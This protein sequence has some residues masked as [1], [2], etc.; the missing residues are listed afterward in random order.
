MR[1]VEVPP[2]TDLMASLGAVGY[3]FRTAL[4][5]IVDNSIT[6]GARNVRISFEGGKSPYIA[7]TDDGRGMG[8][9]AL[10]VAMQL[11]G[12]GP[13]SRRAET[14]LGRFGL[15]LKTASFSQCRCLSVCT[16][17]PD[18][19]IG[20]QW[21]Q[22]RIARTQRWALATFVEEEVAEQLH[23]GLEVPSP[24]GTTVV[25]TDLEPIRMTWGEGEKGLDLAMDGAVDWLSLVF[26]RFLNGDHVERINI[27]VNGN[28]VVGKDP[29]L[30]GH[31]ATSVQSV[32]TF[33]TASGPVRVTPVTLPHQDKLGRA[34][35]ERLGLRGERL[36]DTQ[37]FYVYRANRLLRRGKWFHQQRATD[38]TK[39]TRV[40]VDVGND[41]DA[42]WSLDIKKSV[43]EPPR[44][45]LEQLK[46]FMDRMGSPSRRTQTFRGRKADVPGRVWQYVADRDGAFRY[47]INRDHPVLRALLDEA[48][49]L[50]RREV[51][52]MVGII[53]RTFPIHDAALHING[54]EKVDS[55]M[56]DGE[57]L[58]EL[59]MSLQRRLRAIGVSDEQMATT[60]QTFEPLD[61]LDPESI[62]VL[63]ERE[64]MDER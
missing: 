32:Q 42:A 50:L 16:R 57:V 6:A 12:T 35:R 46:V 8:R 39:L 63:L 47:E 7:V 9:E 26:H 41:M 53:E 15:G 56:P 55:S 5:D 48:D 17:G 58:L 45:L 40:A 25:W 31:R 43:A 19:L 44:A 49:P 62:R 3:E 33:S 37:G 28:P 36:I 2:S 38:R 11:A 61:Q 21:D 24:S 52:N 23:H 30:R 51:E 22:A 34:E 54:D 4:A 14:D 18:G 60:L 1:E 59:V 27:R 29:F 10:R 20:A 13:G 64:E